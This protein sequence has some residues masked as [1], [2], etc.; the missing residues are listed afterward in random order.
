[1]AHFSEQ[2]LLWDCIHAF[3]IGHWS[4]GGDPLLLIVINIFL[5][6]YSYW[7]QYLSFTPVNNKTCYGF[8]MRQTEKEVQT[9]NYA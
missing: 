6:L 7:Y 1:M 3:V 2:P 5:Y 4:Q 9:H 8:C